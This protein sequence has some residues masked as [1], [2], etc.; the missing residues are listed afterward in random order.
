[1]DFSLP[2]HLTDLLGELDRFIAAEIEP[3][4]H[5]D[6]NMRFFHHRREF[7]RTDVDA[8]RRRGAQPGDLHRRARRPLG[9]RGRVVRA[10]VRDRLL[11]AN[12]RHLPLPG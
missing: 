2:T 6:D 9:R 8:C 11:V 5:Q 7:A 12:P 10:D 1:M 3:L 4:Q